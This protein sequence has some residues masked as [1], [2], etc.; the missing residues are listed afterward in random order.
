MIHKR[1]QSTNL[2]VEEKTGLHHVTSG[3]HVH[4]Y[5]GA[6]RDVVIIGA[7]SSIRMRVVMSSLWYR[8]HR[9][10][11]KQGECV[12]LQ[13]VKDRCRRR[14]WHTNDQFIFLLRGEIKS[15]CHDEITVWQILALNAKIDMKHLPKNENATTMVVTLRFDVRVRE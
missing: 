12:S 15:R 8:Y 1:N 7:V 11:R 5:Q 13:E 10:N 14:F 9:L 3:V 4:M 2:E 6:K